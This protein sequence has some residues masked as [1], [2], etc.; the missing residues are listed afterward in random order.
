MKLSK[1]IFIYALIVL[2]IIYQIPVLIPAMIALDLKI[3]LS[4]I[5]LYYLYKKFPLKYY[6]FGV[7]LFVITLF[8]TSTYV[9]NPLADITGLIIF[10]RVY[11]KKS[12]IKT[13]FL[14]VFVI[15]IVDF[16]AVPYPFLEYKLIAD[17]YFNIITST[18][19]IRYILAIYPAFYFLEWTIIVFGIDKIINRESNQNYK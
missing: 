13:I 18:E 7:L 17:N 5:V 15:V 19:Y 2:L 1:L 6:L 3:N 16:F 9:L 11:Q 8:S 14:C 10:N 4:F 12:A